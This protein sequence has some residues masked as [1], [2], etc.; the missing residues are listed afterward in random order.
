MPSY[1]PHAERSTGNGTVYA[2]VGSHAN[3][4]IDAAL[5][6]AAR[7]WKVLQVRPDE[8]RAFRAKN[9]H[10]PPDGS[11]FINTTDPSTILNWWREQPTMDVGIETGKVSGF[12]VLDV[13]G[14]EGV[15]DLDAII[16]EHGP[17]PHTV[18]AQSGSGKGC[19]YLFRWPGRKVKTKAKW[20]DKHLD[21]RGDGGIFVAAPSS[22][23]SGGR[24]QWLVHPDDAAIADAPQWLLDFITEPEPP[25][26]PLQST[27]TYSGS[28]AKLADRAR[29]YI[30]K[31]DASIDGSD[32]SGAAMIVARTLRWRFALDEGTAY[33]IFANDFNPRCQPTW[34]EKEIMHKLADAGKPY[35]GFVY[36]DLRDAERPVRHQDVSEPSR[37][38]DGY[39]EEQPPPDLP[40]E[41]CENFTQVPP[42]DEPSDAPHGFV[43]NAIDL[44]ELAAGDYRPT[45]LVKRLLVANQPCVVG[46]PRKSLKTSTMIDFAVSLATATPFLGK[47]Q[48]YRPVRVG[49]LSGESGKSATQSIAL[50]VC[51]AKGI[52]PATI[53]GGM[54]KFEFTLPRLGS[55]IDVGNLVSG[56]KKQKA[57]AAVVDPLYL[58]LAADGSLDTKNLFEVGPLL[59]R[60]GKA[61]LDIGCTPILVHHARKNSVNDQTKPM[62]LEDLRSRASKNSLGNGCSSIAAKCTTPHDP[63][64]IAYGSRQAAPSGMAASGPLT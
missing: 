50:R 3:P 25:P 38:H 63:G 46:A 30:A 14:H 17:L 5:A 10:V 34:S 40:G 32:G 16:A 42:P 45:W 15:A 35:E 44:S 20:H 27:R 28:E 51:K 22:H 58:C 41:T 31:M 1:T 52:D 9:G 36:G 56:L 61:L 2:H 43:Y 13:D 11:S 21:T 62:D 4:I 47:F 8:K 59:M 23:K 53:S 55:K 26:P 24:Y 49:F 60:I 48:V 39:E 29:K 12:W 33:D 18:K 37:P 19:H 6:Y 7:G 54:C 64:S 57:E